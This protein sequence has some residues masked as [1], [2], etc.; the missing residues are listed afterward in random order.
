MTSGSLRSVKTFK[1]AVGT[2]YKQHL[3]TLSDEGIRL[4]A[5]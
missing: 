4:A 3:I 1:R 2:L 5:R